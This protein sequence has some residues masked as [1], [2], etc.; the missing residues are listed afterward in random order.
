MLTS[1]FA[2]RHSVM[3]SARAVLLVPVFV[4]H[5]QN[6]L[7]RYQV[8]C[9]IGCTD[10]LRWYSLCRKSS[11]SDTSVGMSLVKSTVPR[12]SLRP[13]RRLLEYPRQGSWRLS[14]LPRRLLFPL[15]L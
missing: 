2:V 11:L 12:L 7:K 4:V 6:S 3:V 10:S 14:P 8:L 13:C 1:H 9:S 15:P 5:L